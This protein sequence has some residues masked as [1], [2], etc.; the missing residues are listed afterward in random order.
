MWLEKYRPKSLDDI[1]GQDSAVQKIV[2]WAKNPKK[3][4]LVYGPPGTGKTITAYA[5]ANELGWEIVEMNASDFRDKDEVKA[6]LI[7]AGLQ[8][9]FFAKG[10]LLLVDEVD[11]LFRADSGGTRA[12]IELLKTSRWPVYMTCNDNWAGPVRALK[13]YAI[14]I[15]FKKLRTSSIVKILARICE[16]ENIEYEKSA[17]IQLASQ[18]DVR[19]AILDLEAA[20]AGKTKLALD[21]LSVLGSRDRGKSI[22]EVLRDLFKSN[23][24]WQVRQAIEGL[25][26]DI[27]ELMY[28]LDEN[29]SVEFSSLQEIADAYDA[30][31][32]AD[33]FR[34]R[35]TRRQDWSLLSFVIDLATVGVASARKSR[36]STF[37]PYRPPSWLQRMGRSKANRASLNSLLEKIGSHTHCS[38]KRAIDYLPALSAMVS[39]GSRPFDIEPQELA[40]LKQN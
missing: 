37:T 18:K 40:L 34:G 21:D 17:L 6:K 23:S 26:K 39:K 32:R 36:S 13:P 22:F 4:A 16:S 19:A 29:I 35:I 33:V 30:L 5:L 14:E 15:G 8:A 2:D 11:A 24:A 25:D 7:Q 28:W 10:K 9:S 27:N 12:L 31:S 1:V 3:A 38:K 20:A